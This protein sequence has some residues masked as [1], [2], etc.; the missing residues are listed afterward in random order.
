[1]Q[2]KTNYLTFHNR[3]KTV[4]STDIQG[5]NVVIK[6]EKC[7][8]FLGVHLQ[9]T[10]QW[11]EHCTALVTTLCK[12]CYQMK[13][14]NSILCVEQLRCFYFAEVHSRLMY[15][16]CFWGCPG[17]NSKNVFRIEKRIIR[18]MNLKP[19]TYPSKELFKSCDILPLPCIFILEV[20][21]HTVK[22][23]NSLIQI[24]MFTVM[25]LVKKIIFTCHFLCVT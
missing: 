25:T 3:Q 16:V 7:V 4:E 21:L 17:T 22:Q 12:V 18:N 8:K 14:L 9:D 5:N 19:T 15:G 24:R 13:Y 10:L 11:N 20:L 23:K 2:K 6:A 1:M